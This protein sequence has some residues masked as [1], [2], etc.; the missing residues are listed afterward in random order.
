MYCFCVA[1][2]FS[3]V[4]FFLSIVVI[5]GGCERRRGENYYVFIS[6]IITIIFPSLSL[7]I[8]ISNSQDIYDHDSVL[9]PWLITETGLWAL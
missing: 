9:G 3:D 4:P 7:R 6:L 5:V 8:A 2:I 1:R